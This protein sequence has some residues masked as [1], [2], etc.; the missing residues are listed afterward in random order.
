MLFFSIQVRY[1]QFVFYYQNS[2]LNFVVNRS[3]LWD[4]KQIC[5][6]CLCYEQLKKTSTVIIKEFTFQSTLK[7]VHR[8][9]FCVTASVIQYFWIIPVLKGLTMCKVKGFPSL[10]L[11]TPGFC[12][13]RLTIISR[14]F[15]KISCPTFFS[16]LGYATV[17]QINGTIVLSFTFFP[18]VGCFLDNCYFHISGL[19]H[20]HTGRVDVEVK[21]CQ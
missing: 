16:G 9:R 17:E 5:N 8:F 18:C 7:C 2:S 13:L 20:L 11:S 14:Y 1:K 12:G 15:C 3:F 19:D 10:A 4:I 21:I 6:V